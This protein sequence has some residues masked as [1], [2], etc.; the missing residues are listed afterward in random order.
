MCLPR[1][2]ATRI[3][4]VT[5]TASLL[6]LL[7]CTNGAVE[8][9]GPGESGEPELDTSADTSDTS[10][11]TS[12]DTS[13]VSWPVVWISEAMS[14]N[15]DTLEDGDGD[16]PDWIEL[17]NP[18]PAPVDLSGWTLTDDEATWA[19]P[20][21]TLPGGGFTVVYA[22]GKGADAPEGELHT[23]F[24]L[25]AGGETLTLAHPDATTAVTVVLPALPPD[26]SWGLDEPVTSVVA[27]GDGSG[28]TLAEAEMAGWTGPGFDDAG[29]SGVVLGVGFDGA[30]TTEVIENA[31]IDRPTTQSTDGYGRTGIQAVDGELSTF[32]HSGDPDLFPWWAVDLEADYAIASIR[33]YN[34]T[35]CCAER[36]YNIDVTV[37]DAAGAEVWRE[38][39]INPVAE[40]TSPTTPGATLSLTLDPPVLGRS[41]RVDKTAV[42]GA[43]STEWLSLAEVVVTGRLASPYESAL[44]TDLGA[45]HG[46]AIYVRA[47]FDL[48]APPTRATLAMAYDDGFAA[49]VNGEAAASA[50]LGSAD[51]GEGMVAHD[52]AEA[53]AFPLDPRA[54]VAG[55]NVLA[56][57]GRNVTAADDDLLV[58]PTLTL[59]WISVGAPA[60]FATATPGEPNGV[61]IEG[62]VA[63]PTA[64]PPRGFYDAPFAATV[65]TTTP[66]A[67]LVYTLDGS[68]PTLEHGVVVLPADAATAP[69]VALDVPTTAILRAAAFRESW[70]PS[71]VVT[72]SYLFLDDVIEQPAAP[73]GL[74]AV[75]DGVTEVAVS[76]DYEMDP[77][78]VATD[79]AELLEGLRAIPTLSVVMDPEDLFGADG[80]YINSA[81]RGAAWERAASV[82]WIETDGATGFAET[83]GVRVHGYGWRYHTS[84]KKH[85]LRLEFRSEYGASRLEY[86]VF[87]DSPIDE[88]DSIVLRAGG[89]K[90]WLD[91]R[92]PAQAQYLHDSFARDTA[93]DMG[94]ADGHATYVHLYL[95]GLYWGLYNPVERPEADFG[96]AYFGGD[97]SEYDAIN[98]RTSTNEAID[99]T[100]D[101]YNALLALA[102]EDLS[103]SYADVEAML[104]IDDLIDYMLINQYTANR[105]GPCCAESNNMRGLRRRV[106][107]EPFRFFVWDMEYSLWAAT[108]AINVDIDVS[109]SISHVY[110]RLRQNADFRARYAE[111]ARMHLTGSGALTPAATS[112]RYA[113]RAEEIYG[114]LLGE[115]ARWGDTYRTAPY[116]RE[117]EWQAE[118]DRL[119]A[120]F[121]PFRTDELI[122]QLTAA[123]LYVP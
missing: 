57:E 99:G 62:L 86:P 29:W 40:G 4:R 32:S 119:Q 75:W 17:Y 9:A 94:K 42:N 82:E 91:F 122:A 95:N 66:G 92:D 71:D 68:V 123:G 6:L 34:R 117:V 39:T 84:T 26:V 19:F 88:F 50:N 93:R 14:D 85:S 69:T 31:A 27:V 13:G 43:G 46:G 100:L 106:D 65:T 47:P 52:G 48:A 61:G 120:E 98:R 49:W 108:D 37:L 53:E 81:E 18:G 72:H 59:D 54:F 51:T 5:M 2:A 90:T 36:L 113:A 33:L 76:A 44:T 16:S 38:P 55:G 45:V 64:D 24:R 104:G 77:E 96:A 67:T 56:I 7:A 41:V 15:A 80:L 121:F 3:L 20:T 102:D 111:R 10:A 97:S 83:C 87:A 109:G 25:D 116:R 114:P 22:S 73:A 11:D 28:A 112:A 118:Y 23:P 74:P 110:T 1:R 63:A 105:D 21:L 107:G 103:A 35:D 30:A 115:S 101:A 70:A 58:R 12:G 60:F 89:S 8:P 78:I 79:R